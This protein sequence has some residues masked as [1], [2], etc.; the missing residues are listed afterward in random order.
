MLEEINDNAGPGEKFSWISDG[1]FISDMYGKTQK[2]IDLTE[3]Q[4]QAIVNIYVK[5]K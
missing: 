3:K 2:N 4:K 1:E 5:A